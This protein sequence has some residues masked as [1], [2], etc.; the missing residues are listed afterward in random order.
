MMIDDPRLLICDEIMKHNGTKVCFCLQQQ[1]LQIWDQHGQ[2]GIGNSVA[3]VWSFFRKFTRVCWPCVL[4]W[5]KGARSLS[6]T[7]LGCWERRIGSS[8]A[9]CRC[10][11]PLAKLLLVYYILTFYYYFL[12][13]VNQPSEIIDVTRD[14]RLESRVRAPV[15][16]DHEWDDWRH[17]LK[18]GYQE[19]LFELR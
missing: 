15:E 16:V 9:R 6:E 17:S 18:L 14:Q 12:F 2:L 19:S 5:L 1:A 10:S 8:I 13:L 7:G 3:W 4:P 11:R